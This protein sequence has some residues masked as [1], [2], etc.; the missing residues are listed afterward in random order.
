MC[1]DAKRHTDCLHYDALKDILK[2]DVA[3][4]P[5]YLH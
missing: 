3:V 4:S 5:R 1:I 2:C